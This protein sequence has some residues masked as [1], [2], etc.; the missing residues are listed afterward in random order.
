MKQLFANAENRYKFDG[1][2]K[3]DIFMPIDNGGHLLRVKEADKK[4]NKCYINENII[5]CNHNPSAHQLSEAIEMC[6]NYTS[7]NIT[8]ASYVG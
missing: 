6:I 5:Y 8:R 4:I 3:F 1:K 2:W 7:E